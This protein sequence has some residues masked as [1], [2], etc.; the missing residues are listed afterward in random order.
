MKEV[1]KPKFYWFD[2]G[3]LNVAAGG[4]DQP[5]PSDWLGVLF[6]H[7]IYHELK[8]YLDYQGTRGTLGF[9]RTPSGS[10]VDFI[11]WYGDQAVGIEVK[12]AKTF[13]REYL[14][15]IKSLNQNLPLREAYVVYR[16]QEDL[17][18]DNVHIL[19]P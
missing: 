11:W 8:S 10:E 19:N 4:F 18:V 14:K 7:W 15:G 2:P 12:S 13:R 9:W 1:Q 6:E 17:F 16:G 3:V 5:M